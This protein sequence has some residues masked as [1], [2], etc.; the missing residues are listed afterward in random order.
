M[1]DIGWDFIDD[2]VWIKPEGAVKNRVGGFSRHRKPLA[3]K[4]NSVTEY[5]M[6]YRKNTNGLIDKII[7]NKK[8]E[9][10]KSI[11]ETLHTSNVLNASPSKSKDHPAIMPKSLSDFFV[12]HYSLV[13]DTVFDPFMG[14]G[15]TGISAVSHGRKFFGVERDNLYC[16]IATKNINMSLSKFNTINGDK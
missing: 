4:P 6:V 9:I 13:G 10:S 8:T 5:F 14:I 7:K 3:Y 15:T 2:F 1:I 12:K 16:S 11:I